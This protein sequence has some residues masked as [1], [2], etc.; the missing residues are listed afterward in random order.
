MKALS[1]LIIL[2]VSIESGYCQLGN[3]EY[4]DACDKYRKGDLIGALTDF[5]RI[6]EAGTESKWPYFWRAMTRFDLKD[7]FGAI[8]DCNKAIELDPNDAWDYELRGNCKFELQDFRGAISDQTKAIE[9]QPKSESAHFHRARA[10]YSLKDYQG[11]IADNT[12][13]LENG[14]YYIKEAYFNRGL[15]KIYLGQKDSGCMD[16]S[17]SGELGFEKAYEAIQRNCQ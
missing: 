2:L 12:K 14:Y 3:E 4:M 8:S 16:F 10:K 6:I 9:L 11:S 1:F 5:D 7:F 13:A 15:A 17:K